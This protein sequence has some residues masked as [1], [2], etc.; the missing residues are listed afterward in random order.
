MEYTDLYA[1]NLDRPIETLL[2]IDD[3]DDDDYGDNNNNS[4]WGVLYL[5]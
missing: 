2:I 3:D 5:K 4:I 1:V